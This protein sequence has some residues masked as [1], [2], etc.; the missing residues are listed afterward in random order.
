MIRM[1]KNESPIKPID[2]KTLTQII[3]SSE[4]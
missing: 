3:L 1:N 2:D 4:Y